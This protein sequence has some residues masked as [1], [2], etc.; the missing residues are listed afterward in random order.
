MTAPAA[1]VPGVGLT[2]FRALMAGFPTGV[3]VVAAFD[4]EG[5]PRGMTCTSVCAVSL[6]PPILLIC[7][8]HGSPTL[9]AILQRATFTVNLLHV[10]AEPTAKLFA[11]GQPNRFDA[12]RWHAG[13]DHAG[14]YFP[15]DAHAVAECRVNRTEPVG[16]HTVVFGIVLRISPQQTGTPLL[17]GLR[18]YAAWPQPEFE[19]GSRAA[20]AAMR[21]LRNAR[22][23]SGSESNAGSPRRIAW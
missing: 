20:P 18:Q 15:D 6:T 11:S 4:L 5:R 17:Y 7:I 13:P 21:Q 23:S 9:E 2:D 10:G 14:P 8:R 22:S 1:D 16:D 12:V 3:A 19:D